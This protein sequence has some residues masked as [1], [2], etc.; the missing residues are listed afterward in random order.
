MELKV[1]DK[2][3]VPLGIV[4]E[5][6]SLLWTTKYFD[7]GTFSLLAPVTENNKG[8]LVEGNLVVKHQGERKDARTNDG[9][10]WRRAAQI[11]YVH[12][13]KDENGLEQME[14]QGH[15]LGKWLDKR[16]VCPQVVV[17]ATN[18][19]IIN[20]LVERNCGDEADERRRF[21]KFAMLPQEDVAGGLVEYAS[22]A[23]AGLGLE[24]RA[25]A[26]AGKLGYDILVNEREQK[27]GFYL[28]KGKDLTAT[29]GVGNTPCVFSR[30]FDNVN[31]Q[32]YT[33]SIENCGNFV[34]VQGAADEN[35]SQPTVGVDGAEAA[36]LELDEVFCD[37]TDIAR[38]YRSGDAEVAIPLD[39]YMAMLTTRGIAELERY[40][41]V[42]NFE[43]VINTASN[44]KFKEDFDLG[45][46]VTCKDK[47]WG[48]QI[49]ARITEITESY[50]KGRETVEATFGDSLPTLADQIRKVR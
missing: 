25:R 18:Q 47:R 29:N 6:A 39:T 27:Y 20:A 14:A 4:D 9:G 13:T 8:L 3:L 36:G 50:Q 21:P 26:Q 11:T 46:R 19:D 16:L 43:S 37:A 10:T 30:D 28:Y 1:F 23:Y 42:I 12:V 33:A 34:Y 31:E 48:I 22:E 35:G 2:E 15:M 38:K 7:V 32:E 45:D 40:G 44:L 49:D 24:V 5:M 41:K 17:T